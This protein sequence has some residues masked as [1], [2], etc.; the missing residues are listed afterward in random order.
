MNNKPI[1]INDATI[2][3][4]RLLDKGEA[5][6]QLQLTPQNSLVLFDNKLRPIWPIKN[7]Y[8]GVKM[9]FFE[10]NRYY[11]EIDNDKF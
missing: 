1:F 8:T 10:N 2:E 9:M 6:Y 11:S 3:Q 4:Y 7:A 5:F